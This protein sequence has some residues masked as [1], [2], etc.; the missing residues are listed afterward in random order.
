[1]L[2]ERLV[3]LLPE[4]RLNAR[5][6]LDRLTQEYTAAQQQAITA[7]LLEIVAGYNLTSAREAEGSA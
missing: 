5:R 2:V 3:F 4:E 7:A 6:V 1:M